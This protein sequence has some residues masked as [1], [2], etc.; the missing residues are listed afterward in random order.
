MFF[1]FSPR[2]I[3]QDFAI[4]GNRVELHPNGDYIREFLEITFGIAHRLSVEHQRR[5]EIAYPFFCFI[6]EVEFV[7]TIPL[8]VFE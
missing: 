6:S 4:V 1:Q 3:V 8:D 5:M 7:V 2:K